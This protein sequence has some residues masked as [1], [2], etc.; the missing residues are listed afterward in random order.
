MA[1]KH[2]FFEITD[3]CNEDCVHCDKKWRKDGG[4]TMNQAM[5]DKI[6]A[7]PK[8]SL[9]IS[10]GEPALAKK[11]VKY[12]IEKSSSP[13]SINTNLT[14]WNDEDFRLFKTRNTHLTVSVVSLNRDTY[15]RITGKDLVNKLKE[16]LSKINPFN[17][18][19]TII[20]N[21]YNMDELEDMVNYLAVR[22]FNDFTIQP[23]IPGM[24]DKFNYD[25]YLKRL[26]ALKNV[27]YKHRNI[28]IECM[29]YYDCSY[30]DLPVN[31][32]CEAGTGRLVILSNGDI[33]PCACMAPVIMGDIMKDT[34]DII[35]A[36][37]LKYFNSFQGIDRYTCKGFLSDET[38]KKERRC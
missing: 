23:A 36:A 24:G 9:T 34:W 22:S 25:D 15:K 17:S 26:N 11:Q 1:A 28:N 5:L 4:H 8:E 31:H 32:R 10:G 29:S 2:I 12:I 14:L 35:E 18:S 21:N 30:G 19:I 37:G 27:Y 3:I 16:N 20:V 7:I 13:V 38:A 6:L 33:V